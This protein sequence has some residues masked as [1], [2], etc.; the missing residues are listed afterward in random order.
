VT[1]FSTISSGKY[2]SSRDTEAVRESNALDSYHTSA[3]P[4]SGCMAEGGH[5]FDKASQLGQVLS[6]PW[7]TANR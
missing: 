3:H 5:V 6:N 7:L 2:V 1:I 4:G